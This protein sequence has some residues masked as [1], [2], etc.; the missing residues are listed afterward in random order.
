MAAGGEVSESA[1]DSTVMLLRAT[2][3]AERKHRGQPRKGADGVPYITHPIEVARILAEEGGVRDR[4]V[5]AAA[6]LHDVLEDTETTWDELAREFGEPVAAVVAEVTDDKALPK[7]ERKRR[8]V[9]HA[10]HLSDRAKLV[11]LADKIDNVRDVIRGPPTDWPLE[12]R[13]EYL[14]W[15]EQVVNGLRGVNRALEVAFPRDVGE[16][17]LR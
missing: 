7:A 15:A 8:Q 4:V 14:A 10:P 5:L 9:E 3:F 1:D 6:L 17:P 11:K 16:T 12:R 2:A 13:R